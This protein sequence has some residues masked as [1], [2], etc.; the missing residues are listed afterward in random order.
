MTWRVEDRFPTRSARKFADEAID[1]L[2]ES[3]PMSAFIDAW[4]AA[5]KKAGGIDKPVKR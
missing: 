4:L 3:A 1:E 2:P 5:Y